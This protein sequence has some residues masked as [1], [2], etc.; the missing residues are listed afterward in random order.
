MWARSNL[1]FRSRDARGDDQPVL[2]PTDAETACEPPTEPVE[3][4]W[5][6]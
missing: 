6:G 5:I 2:V 4:G 1:R 3:I